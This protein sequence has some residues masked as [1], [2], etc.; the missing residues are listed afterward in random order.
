MT[1]ANPADPRLATTR[2]FISR[3]NTTA[4]GADG[5]LMNEDGKVLGPHD[6]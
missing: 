5:L 3:G 6:V 2:L 4:H 1:G